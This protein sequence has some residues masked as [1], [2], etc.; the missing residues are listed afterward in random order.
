[1][2]RRLREHSVTGI[3]HVMLRGINRQDILSALMTIFCLCVFLSTWC[4]D[5]MRVEGHFHR[6][7][8]YMHTA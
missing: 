4:A 5:M 7:V 8:R 3:Y 6:Y 1:M 2:P